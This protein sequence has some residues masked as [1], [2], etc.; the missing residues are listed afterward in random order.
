MK[1]LMARLST[2][3]IQVPGDKIATV[4]S[5]KKADVDKAV[6]AL[7]LMHF[8]IVQLGENAGF[9]ERAACLHRIADAVEARKARICDR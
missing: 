1:P 4:T 9:A 8:T 5:L 6:D 7:Q 2:F 3:W